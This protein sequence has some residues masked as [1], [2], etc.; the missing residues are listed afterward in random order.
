VCISRA[1]NGCGERII[2]EFKLS[3]GKC[4]YDD[5]LDSVVLGEEMSYGN[6]GCTAGEE[7]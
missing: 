4:F 2:G 3:R 7:R 1:K 6:D 5:D